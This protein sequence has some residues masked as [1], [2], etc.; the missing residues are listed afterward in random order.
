L[1]SGNLKKRGD[2]KQL[3]VDGGL[4]GATG[5]PAVVLVFLQ[6]IEV[7]PDFVEAFFVFSGALRHSGDVLLPG[8]VD[9]VNC[10][11]HIEVLVHHQVQRL[12]ERE[13]V[14]PG[15]LF[16]CVVRNVMEC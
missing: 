7:F 9:E 15:T 4:V 12:G 5:E 11:G 6:A 14:F 8:F 10:F 3:I 2:K 16:D 13:H 1:G